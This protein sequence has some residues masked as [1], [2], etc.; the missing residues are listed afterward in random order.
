MRRRKLN[1]ASRQLDSLLAGASIGR[2][3]ARL[4]SVDPGPYAH[5]GGFLLP[6]GSA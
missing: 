2:N 5:F 3:H 4:A 6:G 1:R